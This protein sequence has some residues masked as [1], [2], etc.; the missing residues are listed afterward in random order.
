[1]PNWSRLR[2]LSRNRGLQR[3][4]LC[5]GTALAPSE[6]GRPPT[7]QKASDW[8]VDAAG[9]TCPSAPSSD[10]R[11]RADREAVALEAQRQLAYRS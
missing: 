5:S 7:A 11:L 4:R 6:A 2:G 3:I 8:N 10:W 9:Q 1:M